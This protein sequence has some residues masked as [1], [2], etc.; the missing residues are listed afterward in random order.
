MDS[1]RNRL[2]HTGSESILMGDVLPPLAPDWDNPTA[3]D[4]PTTEQTMTLARVY[5]LSRFLPGWLAVAATGQLPARRWRELAIILAS[6]MDVTIDMDNDPVVTYQPATITIH[7]H[8]P[9]PDPEGKTELC[10]RCGMP[11]Q[12]TE[13]HPEPP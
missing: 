11:I 9:N 13:L 12:D 4:A 2:G 5:A 8:L 1:R 7:A 6:T 3:S 10:G